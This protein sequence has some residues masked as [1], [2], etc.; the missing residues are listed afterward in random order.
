MRTG[1]AVRNV[2]ITKHRS[3]RRCTVALLLTDPFDLD[4]SLSRNRRLLGVISA[5]KGRPSTPF[6]VRVYAPLSLLLQ[7]TSISFVIGSHSMSLNVSPV[8]ALTCG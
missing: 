4:T 5:R 8:I 6:D 1:L 3:R 2:S 7:I